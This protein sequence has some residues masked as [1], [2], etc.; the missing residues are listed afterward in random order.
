M[1]TIE[2]FADPVLRA[3]FLPA[4]VCGLGVAVLA[5][6]LSMLVVLKRL[7]FIGQGVSHAAF[8]GVGVAAAL[9]LAGGGLGAEGYAV[10][11]AFCFGAAWVIGLLEERRGG[12][13]D[14]SIGV[15]LV[16]S[17]ALGSMLMH[18]SARRG[19]PPPPA[20][21]SVLFGSLGG[22]GWIDVAWA[23]GGAAVVAL[24]LWWSRR[25]LWFWAFDEE[26]AAAFGAP[27][28]ALRAVM[29]GLIAGVV[30]IAMKLVGVVLAT[31]LLVL[32]GAIAL[33]LS[34]RLGRVM[35]W[36]VCGAVGAMLAG[37]FA[38]FELDLPPGAAVVGA[39]TIAYFCIR[40]ATRL[41]RRAPATRPVR[42]G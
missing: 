30:V 33:R 2:Y 41:G 7:A 35:G 17:M 32:P 6:M 10:V 38:S 18:W 37:L 39:L 21:E 25:W 13:L 20:W 11:A 31:A 42:A 5:S 34:D 22:V 15:V 1:R 3:A 27:S 36:S 26:A 12:G 8:G 28:V 16:A 14:T 23:W 24:V 29:L 19:G 4:V 40:V 9:G